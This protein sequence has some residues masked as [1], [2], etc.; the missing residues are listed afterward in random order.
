[1]TKNT[2]AGRLG[3]SDLTA[4]ITQAA[5][6]AKARISKIDG[7]AIDSVAGGIDIGGTIGGDDHDDG[8][9]WTTDG[10][11]MPDPFPTPDTLKF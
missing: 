7:D 5:E 3:Q 11:I 10:A 6:E 8:D 9:D 4:A 1:M 2:K